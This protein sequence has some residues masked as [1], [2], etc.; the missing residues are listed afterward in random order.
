M[1]ETDASKRKKEKET[2][3][4]FLTLATT[5]DK[6]LYMMKETDKMHKPS[7][8]TP[9]EVIGCSTVMLFIISLCFL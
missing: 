2:E 9:M 4:K 3:K 8:I 7:K 6:M 5:C 1:V